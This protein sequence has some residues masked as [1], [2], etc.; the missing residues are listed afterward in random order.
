MG[1]VDAALG[2]LV[3]SCGRPA[4]GVEEMTRKMPCRAVHIEERIKLRGTLVSRNLQ[5]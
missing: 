3:R 1:V 5:V 2:M 4:V